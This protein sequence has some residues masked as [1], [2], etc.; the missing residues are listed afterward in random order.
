MPTIRCSIGPSRA[1]GV[2]APIRWYEQHALSDV[3]NRILGKRTLMT[4]SWI[5]V[6]CLA[7]AAPVSAAPAPQVKVETIRHIPVTIVTDAYFRKL[8]NW[9]GLAHGAL[10]LA[11]ED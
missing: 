9:R 3:V 4:K 5:I 8:P 1:Y 6:A 11:T 2:D 10:S 7:G